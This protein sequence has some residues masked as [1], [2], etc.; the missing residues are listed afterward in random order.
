[1]PTNRIVSP[2][3]RDTQNFIDRW[4]P[5]FLLPTP[6]AI[7]YGADNLLGSGNEVQGFLDK[8][9]N[10]IH[11]MFSGGYGIELPRVAAINNQPSL[12]FTTSIAYIGSFNDRTKRID[13]HVPF[14]TFG[15]V[16]LSDWYIANGGPGYSMIWQLNDGPDTCGL[17][18][19]TQ[20]PAPWPG[21]TEYLVYVG[22]GVVPYVGGNKLNQNYVRR[23]FAYCI[24][25]K[26]GGDFGDP[27]KWDL[28]IDSVADEVIPSPPYEDVVP[29]VPNLLTTN[30]P[31][32]PNSAHAEFFFL[33][34]RYLQGRDLA[35]YRAYT[36]RKY[37]LGPY[38]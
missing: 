7:W 13:K 34:G 35:G 12:Q 6:G 31:S 33:P 37:K 19:T 21:Y 1:M 10:D 36:Q 2:F 9:G 30:N 27:T 14:C 11:A 22:D 18:F 25:Y 23:Y 15:V 8:S 24:N 16:I 20:D 3:D 38:T 32:S 5:E 28:I 4:D 29:D 26:G 17:I